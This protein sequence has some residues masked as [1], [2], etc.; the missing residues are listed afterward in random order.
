[1]SLNECAPQLETLLEQHKQVILGE[2]LSVLRNHPTAT[3]EAADV[4]QDAML[5]LCE[6]KDRVLTSKNRGAY[7]RRIV[8][9]SAVKSVRANMNFPD[10][11]GLRR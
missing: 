11:L 4:V 1:M 7:I 6:C 9:C 2:S 3:I 10:T 8:H 5:E